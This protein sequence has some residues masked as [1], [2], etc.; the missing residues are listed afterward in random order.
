MG[1]EADPGVEDAICA[2]DDD[3]NGGDQYSGDYDVQ[4]QKTREAAEQ[5]HE[6]V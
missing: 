2:G 5:Q 3:G 6:E 1:A 4:V